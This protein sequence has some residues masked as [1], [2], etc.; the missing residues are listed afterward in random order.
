MN[1][2]A[3]LVS[4]LFV[5]LVGCAA[6]QRTVISPPPFPEGVLSARWGTSVEGVKEAVAEE[7]HRWFQDDTNSPPYAGYAA[8]TYL[9]NPAI[10]SYFFTPKSKRLFRID[11]TFNDPRIY[12]TVRGYLI[13]KFKS[14]NFSQTDTDL[15]TWDDNS[16]IIFQKDSKIVQISYST[17][18]FLRLNQQEGGS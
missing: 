4:G 8:G 1:P 11:V 17:G 13:Q 12:D 9:N 16:L 3:F 5:I 18:P 15:W 2:K 7:G 6:Q 14:P 10:F